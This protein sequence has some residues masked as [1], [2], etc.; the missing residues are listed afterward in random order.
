MK[1]LSRKKGCTVFKACMY[2]LFSSV[3]VGYYTFTAKVYPDIATELI[4]P[5]KHSC[6]S[7]TAMTLSALPVMGKSFIG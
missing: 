1:S 5:S 7:N 4:S 2:P 3:T 6:S